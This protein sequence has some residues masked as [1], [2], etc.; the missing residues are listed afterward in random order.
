[1][2]ELASRLNDEEKQVLYSVMYEYLYHDKRPTALLKSDVV[3]R[4]LDDALIAKT[5]IHLDALASASRMDVLKD[6]VCNHN[7][8]IKL[9]K[10]SDILAALSSD[11]VDLFQEY[12]SQFVFVVPSDGTMLAPRKI[13]QIVQPPQ[14]DLSYL[15]K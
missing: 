11:Y 7:C 2:I 9:K 14:E 3:L 4:L 1:M 10:K 15:W 6:F 8:D 13:Y 5:V 12:V